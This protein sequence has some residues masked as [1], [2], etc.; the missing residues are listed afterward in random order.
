MCNFQQLFSTLFRYE[1]EIRLCSGMEYTFMELKKVSG[2]GSFSSTWSLHQPARSIKA[3][4]PLRF[5]RV[6]RSWRR[7]WSGEHGHNFNRSISKSGLLVVTEEPRG[8]WQK[9]LG[10]SL[11]LC[12][13]TPRLPWPDL[14]WRALYPRPSETTPLLPG[15]F[16]HRMTA[17]V[18]KSWKL[19]KVFA[20]AT[21]CVA[22]PC[23]NIPSQ[24]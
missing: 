22:T 1:D 19:I 2:M 11:S 8:S 9:H 3:L 15:T 12:P 23:L 24:R 18:G 7:Q 14:A 17:Q 10:V 20:F 21:C 16:P 13:A 5:D 4:V 6:I